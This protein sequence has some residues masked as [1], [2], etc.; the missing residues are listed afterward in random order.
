M[1]QYIVNGV[2]VK[3]GI[4]IPVQE[5]RA[6]KVMK[7][8]VWWALYIWELSVVVLCLVNVFKFLALLGSDASVDAKIGAFSEALGGF[9]VLAA[10]DF[11][12]ATFTTGVV[13][14]TIGQ[15]FKLRMRQKAAVDT[16]AQIQN[17]LRELAANKASV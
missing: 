5:I 15:T 9:V 14:H 3:D 2:F 11:V 8:P 7:G 10:I 16:D 6:S 1:S 13:I 17:A 12:R 4:S